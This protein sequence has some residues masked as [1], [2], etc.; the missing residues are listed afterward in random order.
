MSTLKE[1]N[2]RSCKVH[3]VSIYFSAARK[4]EK[5]K[6]GTFI[7]LKCRFLML[8]HLQYV[9]QIQSLLELDILPQYIYKNNIKTAVSLNTLTHS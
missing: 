8:V 9:D 5:V 6:P 3:S 7:L 4:I 2:E 1:Q